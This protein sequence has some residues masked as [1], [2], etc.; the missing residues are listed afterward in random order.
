MD[1][2]WLGRAADGRLRLASKLRE[3]A[4]G[5]MAVLSG[6]S[7]QVSASGGAQRGGR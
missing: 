6:G 7:K 2:L 3:A 1:R 4:G 5:G